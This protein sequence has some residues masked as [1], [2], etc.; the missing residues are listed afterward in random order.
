MMEDD[1]EGY[2]CPRESCG[3]FAFEPGICSGCGS[4][5][6]MDGKYIA[7]RRPTAH[8]H[9]G[10]GVAWVKRRSSSS[11]TCPATLPTNIFDRLKGGSRMDGVNDIV[12]M[13]I[14][15]TAKAA[16]NALTK[17]TATVFDSGFSIRLKSLR[18]AAAM[19]QADLAE[20]S[21][22]PRQTIAVLEMGRRDNPTWD[23][24]CRLADGLG[25]TVNDFRMT[26]D[27]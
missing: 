22:V 23:L 19:T 9:I 6:E 16:L 18:T 27:A 12:G 26:A 24:V 21:G 3:N 1:F 10:R 14:Y 15:K 7:S 11:F 25:C 4:V 2:Y 17:A 13:R 8:Y 20:A 5:L